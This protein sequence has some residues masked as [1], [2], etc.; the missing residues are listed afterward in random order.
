MAPIAAANRPAAQDTHA[1][2]PSPGDLPAGHALHVSAPAV[3]TNLPAA[4]PTHNGL[5]AAACASPGVHGKHAARPVAFWCVPAAQ[6]VHRVALS[7]S[8][9]RT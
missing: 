4:Q 7:S 5:P 6:G 8:P 3:P 9:A 1:V 2:L